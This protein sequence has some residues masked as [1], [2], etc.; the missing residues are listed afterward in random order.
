MLW[1]ALYCLVSD[2][3]LLVRDGMASVCDCHQCSNVSN[4]NTT[5]LNLSFSDV[6]RS[7]F[8]IL[9]RDPVHLALLLELDLGCYFPKFISILCNFS[10]VPQSYHVGPLLFNNFL[11]DVTVGFYCLLNREDHVKFFVSISKV[12]KKTVRK[13]EEKKNLL[14]SWLPNFFALCMKKQIWRSL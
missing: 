13:K 8:K 2:I 9:K 3:K 6:K 4:E 11:S 12:R 14:S 7:T 1:H 5:I 10:G